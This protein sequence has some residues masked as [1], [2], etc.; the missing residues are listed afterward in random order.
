M[1]KSLRDVFTIRFEMFLPTEPKHDQANLWKATQT[2][3]K[4]LAAAAREAPEAPRFFQSVGRAMVLADQKLNDGT[5]RTAIS[6]AFTRHAISL[7]SA[8]MLAPRS[9][10]AGGAPHMRGKRGAA[11]LT[12]TTA[13][14]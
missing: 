5:N 6:D 3:G 13:T 12:T 14:I 9:S 1:A 11:I 7:G 4:L 2:V 8:A 10:L